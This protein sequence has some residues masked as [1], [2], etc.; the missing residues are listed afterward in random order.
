[1]SLGQS[2]VDIILDEISAFTYT[3]NPP[4][5]AVISFLYEVLKPGRK[6]LIARKSTCVH[7][8]SN[9]ASNNRVNVNI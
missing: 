2:R 3:S 1:M 4:L 5:L 9:K 7:A 6:S 8:N